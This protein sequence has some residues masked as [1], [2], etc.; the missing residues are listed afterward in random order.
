MAKLLV[1]SYLY[2]FWG[3]AVHSSMQNFSL[4]TALQNSV[5]MF[6]NLKTLG[7]PRFE[8]RTAVAETLPL[9]FGVAKN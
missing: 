7:M 4:G 9:S 2:F 5:E 8:P 1:L 6:L 3:G